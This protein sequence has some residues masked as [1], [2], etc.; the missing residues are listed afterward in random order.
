[1]PGAVKDTIELI[2]KIYHIR[3]CTRKLPQDIGLAKTGRASI[4]IATRRRSLSAMYQG[5]NINKSVNR[6][7]IFWAADMSLSCEIP[8]TG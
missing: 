4:T 8:R 6:A 5:E 1:M 2:H 3:T 7:W